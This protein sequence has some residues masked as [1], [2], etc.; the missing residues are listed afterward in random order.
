MIRYVVLYLVLSGV[1]AGELCLV[2]FGFQLLQRTNFFISSHSIHIVDWIIGEK[3]M[4]NQT[5]TFLAFSLNDDFEL[6]LE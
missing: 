1:I 2:E 5:L 6:P 4:Q 3:Q